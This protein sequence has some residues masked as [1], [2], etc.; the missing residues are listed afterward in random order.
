MSAL[1]GRYGDG[2]YR[3]DSYL[4]GI[5]AA[6]EGEL[7]G[8]RL[9]RDVARRRADALERAKLD[10]I[11]DVERLT[12]R[13]LRG[14]AQRLGIQPNEPGL[15]EV[16]ERRANELAVMGWPEFIAKAQR[17]WPPYIAQFAALEALAPASDAALIRQLVEHEVVLVE[18]AGVEQSA[19][20][21][22]ESLQVLRSFLERS[23][24][25]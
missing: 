5:R 4:D 14:I 11:A 10:A 20:G 12:N 7:I 6:Y 9:Y 24:L 2:S 13:R 19:L 1:D 21:S 25:G 15:R 17:D 23:T 16:I 8:E 3:D 22:L 18:F